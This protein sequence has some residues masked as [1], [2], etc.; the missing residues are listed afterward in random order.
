MRPPGCAQVEYAK[1]DGRWAAAYARRSEA[2]PDVDLSAAF[3]SEAAARRLFDALDA[4]NRVA[5]FFRIYQTKT[6]EKR[7][8][9]ITELVAM[10]NRGET[11]YPRRSRRGGANRAS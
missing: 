6:S 1:A 3:D 8:A 11:I 7:A 10:L 2:A 4:P 5:V 9:K